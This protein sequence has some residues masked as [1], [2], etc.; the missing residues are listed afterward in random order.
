[1]HKYSPQVSIISLGPK[2]QGGGSQNTSEIN[3]KGN[4]SEYMTCSPISQ[5]QSRA[6]SYFGTNNNMSTNNNKENNN[7]Y[8]NFNSIN[9]CGIRELMNSHFEMRN[10]MCKI[11]PLIE[12]GGE[13]IRYLFH[14]Y[15][16]V[17][18]L[19]RRKGMSNQTF[20]VKVR[21]LL[22]TKG[23][24]REEVNPDV[25]H[26][27]HVGIQTLLDV[28]NNITLNDSK[29]IGDRGI[30]PNPERLSKQN[31]IENLE[32][33]ENLDHKGPEAECRALQK[34]N[35]RLMKR[36]AMLEANNKK[37]AKK[38]QGGS[39]FCTPR[40][41]TQQSS[42]SNSVT[43][44][45]SESSTTKETSLKDICTVLK[46]ELK[47]IE[48][49]RLAEIDRSRVS[50]LGQILDY[51]PNLKS[52]HKI[53]IESKL[54]LEFEKKCRKLEEEYKIKEK[55]LISTLKEET[56]EQDIDKS[57]ELEN[58]LEEARNKIL[59]VMDGRD[60]MN[61]Q[62]YKYKDKNNEYLGEL[63]DRDLDINQLKIHIEELTDEN[64]KLNILVNKLK[65]RVTN[66]NKGEKEKNDKIKEL[67]EEMA[68]EKKEL[69]ER[70]REL[71]NKRRD[72]E[73]ELEKKICLYE[74][75]KHKFEVLQDRIST[76]KEFGGQESNKESEEDSINRAIQELS[77][78]IL[79]KVCI[80]IYIYI[81][82]PQQKIK[83][84]GQKPNTKTIW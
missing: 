38:A 67:F 75:F 41:K 65:D 77:M 60:E 44:I 74:E 55:E 46:S 28:A 40:A 51:I 9:A 15:I 33:I 56:K 16:Q 68:D 66:Y 30:H 29:S 36:I 11:S 39:G 27:V 71:E 76:G 53:S 18:D 25:F 2:G 35:R 5:L 58:K 13:W 1:M 59:E 4:H 22:N 79:S 82:G 20:R 14:F 83:C 45:P 84:R 48:F 10:E 21:E 19:E 32:D 80:Y 8:P 63:Q 26:A 78:I 17:G 34:E 50:K 24:I 61:R 43:V 6:R 54:R 12:K 64:K 73:N 37:I 42:G 49:E 57:V 3:T 47:A 81:L 23:Y 62:I 70:V 69:E 52:S 31:T 72:I 7:K